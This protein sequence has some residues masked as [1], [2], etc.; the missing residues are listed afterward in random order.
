MVNLHDDLCKMGDMGI[1]MNQKQ[2]LPTREKILDASIELF[3]R[4]GFKDV[5]VRE[6]AA[7]VGIKASSLY[8]HYK[9]KEDILDTIF[10]V[11]R[12][13]MAATVLTRDELMENIRIISPERFLKETFD[14]FKQ[15]M[16]NPEVVKIA[17]IIAIEQQRNQSVRKFFVEEL[18][19]N[20]KQILRHAF[21]LMIEKHLIDGADTGIL[22]EEYA[23]YVVYLYFEQN[24]LNESLSLEEIERKMERHNEF[25][26]RHILIRRGAEKK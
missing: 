21:D 24:F 19:E 3:A 14:R 16:W 18:I 25:Y 10:L 9:S 4:K 11:F 22:A 15:V 6:I 1:Y 12:Q 17:R 8:K 2:D 23:A 13:K 7:A 26:V 5:S 20:P